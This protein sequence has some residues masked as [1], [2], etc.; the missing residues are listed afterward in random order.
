MPCA[1]NK[2]LNE[3]YPSNLIS[4]RFSIFPKVILKVSSSNPA[5]K[6]DEKCTNKTV[7][8][9]YACYTDNLLRSVP[10]QKYK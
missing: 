10:W 7:S 1:V 8:K 6:V 2:V 9:G 3:I 5:S 4:V